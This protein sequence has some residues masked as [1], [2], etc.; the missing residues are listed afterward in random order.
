MQIFCE[1]FKELRKEQKLST[2]E[3]GKVLNVDHS[4]ILRWEK[5]ERVPSI[6]HLYNIAKF[7]GVT[8]DYLIGLSDY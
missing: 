3:L 2:V 5:G 8:A 4:T 7:F 6:E 1:R